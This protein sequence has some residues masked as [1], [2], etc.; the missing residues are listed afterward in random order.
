MR[1][2]RSIDP[3]MLKYRPSPNGS[4]VLK[5]VSYTHLD[6]YKRQTLFCGLFLLLTAFKAD[7][8]KTTIFMIG[9]STMANKVLTGGNPERGWGQTVS[10]THLVAPEQKQQPKAPAKPKAPVKPTVYPAYPAGSEGDDDLLD[11]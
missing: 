9:D 1:S 7:Q 11:N 5:P 3:M 6:V 10:Y 4:W 2:T 8:H